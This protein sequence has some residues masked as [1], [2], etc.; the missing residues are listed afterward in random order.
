MPLEITPQELAEKMRRGEDF[1][2]LD[3]RE[4]WELDYARLAD[5]RLLVLPM[6]RLAREGAAALP[7]TWN[8][9][10][11]QIITLCHHGVRSLNAAQWL[12]SLGWQNVLSLAGGIDAYARQVDASVG[13]Y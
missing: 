1:I 3:V 8:P 13:R 12:K 5:P 11:S 6:S 10:E 4:L 9:A 2:L 7:Q